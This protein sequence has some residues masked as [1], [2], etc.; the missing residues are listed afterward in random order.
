MENTPFLAFPWGKIEVIAT[1]FTPFIQSASI[2]GGMFI[3]FLILIINGGL[4]F[5]IINYKNK[6]K[7][8]FAFVVISL[9]FITNITVGI[10][11]IK[12]ENKA[13]EFKALVVQGNYS[14][15]SKWKSSTSEMFDTY[16]KLT[17]DGV[18]KDTKLVLW[19]ETAIPTRF[20]KNENY[21]NELFKLAN[22]LNVTIIVGCYTE[23]NSEQ[24]YNSLLAISPNKII[25]KPYCKQ[26]LAPFG[27]YFPFGELFKKMLPDFCDIINKNS[28]NFAGKN[29]TIIDTP[30]GKI[31]GVICY[32][33]IF[34]NISVNNVNNCAEILTVASNDS[35]FGKSVAL[36]QHHSHSIMRA[37]ETNRFVLRASN[38][39][40]SSIISPFGEVVNSAK[41]FV[42]TSCKDYIYLNN[43][44]T[45]YCILGQ[46]FLI[47]CFAVY[48]YSIIVTVFNKD[49]RKR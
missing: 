28:G 25:S 11:R 49:R 2:F 43:E 37:V 5:I 39:G 12:N 19:P 16:L 30:V 22:E 18:D 35:W 14:G 32:E 9:I 42:A 21:E 7:I 23:D 10:L 45:L 13:L 33:S 1:E 44:K 36:Y 24:C 17:R 26:I 34:T 29:T 31:G 4:A 47:P 48:F 46:I 20:Y 38:T 8:V 40:I 3:S 15:L 6:K 41:P 27:E